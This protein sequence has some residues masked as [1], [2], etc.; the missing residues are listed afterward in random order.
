[1]L[2]FVCLCERKRKVIDIT[3]DAREFGEIVS[4]FM[5]KKLDF[6]SFTLF[7]P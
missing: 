5:L 3:I 2:H 6:V 7:Q 1:M 4:V